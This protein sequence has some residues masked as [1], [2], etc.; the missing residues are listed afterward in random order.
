M[1]FDIKIPEWINWITQDKDGEWW[2]WAQKPIIDSIFS[3]W[4]IPNISYNN[5]YLICKTPPPTDYTQEL[6]KITWK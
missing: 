1:Q 3:Q 5:I 6:Y 4:S 2:G